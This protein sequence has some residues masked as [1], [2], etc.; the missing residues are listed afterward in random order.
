MCDTCDCNLL[1]GDALAY[2]AARDSPLGDSNSV[3]G[4]PPIPGSH[5]MTYSQLSK[6]S[7]TGA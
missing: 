7:Q 4:F 5:R 6:K 1:V 3:A 2:V